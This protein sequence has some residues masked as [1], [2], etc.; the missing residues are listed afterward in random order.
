M[1]VPRTLFPRRFRYLGESL[2]PKPHAL[3]APAEDM[4]GASLVRPSWRECSGL[5]FFPRSLAAGD[6]GPMLR[7]LQPDRPQ[8]SRPGEPAGRRDRLARPG[9][10]LSFPLLAAELFGPMLRAL[11]HRDDLGPML[12]LRSR[13]LWSTVMLARCSGLVQRLHLFRPRT[14]SAFVSADRIGS[15]HI[16]ALLGANFRHGLEG[17][18]CPA[19]ADILERVWFCRFIPR[20]EPAIR[21]DVVSQ[22]TF[23]RCQIGREYSCSTRIKSAGFS[24]SCKDL[25][26][27]WSSGPYR[28]QARAR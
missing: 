3:E 8:E 9:R 13:P 5:F 14:S 27:E 24:M 21:A 12:R 11:V 18:G 2:R 15:S 17:V 22:H 19:V 6:I 10:W 23:G 25:P 16:S 4:Y 1:S 26:D 28:I 7:A 20:Q